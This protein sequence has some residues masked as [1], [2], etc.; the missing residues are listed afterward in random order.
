MNNCFWPS[1]VRP[2]EKSK[3]A[4]AR[5]AVSSCDDPNERV[6]CKGFGI[7]MPF[8]PDEVAGM[9]PFQLLGRLGVGVA[10]PPGRRFGR[11]RLEE[12]VGR[13]NWPTAHPIREPG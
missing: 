4:E 12:L 5:A 3:A 11:T 8:D 13:S 2:V 1:G 10:A 7:D 6:I 9:D